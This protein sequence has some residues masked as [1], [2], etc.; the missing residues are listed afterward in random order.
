[1]KNITLSLVVVSLMI[2]SHS[3]AEEGTWK[4]YYNCRYIYDIAVEGDYLWCATIGGLVKWDMRDSTYEIFPRLD[5]GQMFRSKSIFIDKKGNKWV[6]LYRLYQGAQE[7]FGVGRF[8]G[9]SWEVYSYFGNNFDYVHG[10]AEDNDGVMWYA[11]LGGVLNFDGETWSKYTTEDGLVYHNVKSIAV[12]ADNVKWFVTDGGGVSSFDG[13]TW[14]TYTSEDGLTNNFVK[15]I[16]VDDDNVKWFGTSY[17]VSSFDGTTWKIYT[18]ANGLVY[19]NVKSIAVDADN[20]KWFGTFN[21]VSNFNGTTWTTYTTED[22]LASNNVLCCSAAEGKLWFVTEL[23]GY[24]GISEFDGTTW[25]YY[26][27]EEE[28]IHVP[29]NVKKIFVDHTN[30]KWFSGMYYIGLKRFDGNSWCSYSRDKNITGEI[31]SIAENHEGI[32]WFA[33]NDCLI[34]ADGETL[35]FYDDEN[36]ELPSNCIISVFV[37]Y[38]NQ[39]WI[40]TRSGL[41]LYDGSTWT[42]YTQ[43][44]SR[45]PDDDV[46]QI[47]EDQNGMMWFTYFD[48]C[49]C[50]YNGNEWSVYTP[51]NSGLTDNNI[52][53]IFIDKENVKWFATDGGISSFDNTKWENYNTEN[54][55]LVTDD[56]R[57]I[58]VDSKGYLWAGSWYEGLSV[59]DGNTWTQYNMEN[60]SLPSNSVYDIA[61]DHDG[62]IWIGTFDGLA[63]YDPGTSTFVAQKETQPELVSIQG[64]YP[65]PFNSSTTIFF[66][67][68]ASG[69]T[70]LVIYNIT[71]QKV[72]QLVAETITAGIHNVMW[73]GRDNDGNVLSSGVY[74]SRLSTGKLVTHR[75]MLLMK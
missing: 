12:D 67:L 26:A 17:G 71:G 32:M 65:N 35:A 73:D 55:G 48:P 61:E 60:S 45:L 3:P 10:I 7:G 63:S 8:D 5:N 74:I 59:F 29:Q 36:S 19:H 43:E 62:V 24:C 54:S 44:N 13:T 11:T 41:C 50:S 21:G 38:T 27:P 68:P 33:K 42:I 72:R 15:T 34:R 1:M 46:S 66:T 2:C 9:E 18:T 53:D 22:G 20:V 64:A 49:V 58:L 51:E 40:S 4:G 28:Q 39:L 37:D 75:R 30:T 47:A 70:Q 16:A 25:K 52:Y 31:N 56:I 6:S 23:D 57:A 14:T 69:F